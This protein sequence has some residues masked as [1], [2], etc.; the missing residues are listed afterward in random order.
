M[1]CLQLTEF[2]LAGLRIPPQAAGVG[3]TGGFL[4]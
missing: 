3:S 4:V 2:F 1:L